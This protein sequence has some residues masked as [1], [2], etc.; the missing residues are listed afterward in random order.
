MTAG[1]ISPSG[2]GFFLDFKGIKNYNVRIN[3]HFTEKRRLE[4]IRGKGEFYMEKIPFEGIKNMRD[5]GGIRT[6]DGRS[7]RKKKLL[8]SGQLFAATQKDIEIIRWK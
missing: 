2:V 5:L 7:I 8:K 3:I 1:Q 6:A 4:T